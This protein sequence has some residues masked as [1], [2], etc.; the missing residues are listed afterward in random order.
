MIALKYPITISF[1]INEFQYKSFNC[2]NYYFFRLA[3]RIQQLEEEEAMLGLFNK[4]FQQFLQWTDNFE[5]RLNDSQVIPKHSVR[6]KVILLIL[7]SNPQF[8]RLI[9]CRCMFRG[10]CK[11]RLLTWPLLRSIV[12]ARLMS[13]APALMYYLTHQ[14]NL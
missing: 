13:L 9:F 6:R 1:L 8:E 2:I 10:I 14:C 3:I 5:N 12:K 4:R 11:S 7:F